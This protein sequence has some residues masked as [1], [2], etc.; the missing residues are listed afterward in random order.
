M[1]SSQHTR[2]PAAAMGRAARRTVAALRAI[3]H[4]QV[5]MWELFWQSSRVPVGSGRAAGLD[6][7]PGRAAADRQPPA[8]PRRP[9]AAREAHE[10]HP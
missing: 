3:H 1:V 4:E 7:Q 8:H 10:D 6:L 2:R 5:L 9:T